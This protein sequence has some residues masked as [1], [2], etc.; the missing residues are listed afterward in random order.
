MS[1]EDNKAVA[2]RYFEEF[3]DQQR[4]DLLEE[5]VA[6]DAS[7][8]TRVGVGGTGTRD[9]FRAHAQWVWDNVKDLHVTVT[10]LVAEGE[11]VVVYWQIEGIH[12]GHI[13]GVPATGKYF[14]GQSISSL[15]VRDGKVVRYNVLPDRLGIVQQL[16]EPAL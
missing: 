9:D 10:D 7:D 13:F 2:R 1:I 3:V 4:L 15:T 14:K 12:Q 8:E 16:S 6:E 5:L 11:R